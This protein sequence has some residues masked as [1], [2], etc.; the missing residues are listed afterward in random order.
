MQMAHAKAYEELRSEKQ[1]KI[2]MLE[3]NLRKCQQTIVT[4]ESNVL[5]LN[6][7][8]AKKEDVEKERDLWISR[9]DQMEQAKAELQRQLEGASEYIL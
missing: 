2:D 8:I 3:T 4:L 6:T 1:S 5:S 9:H 7:V